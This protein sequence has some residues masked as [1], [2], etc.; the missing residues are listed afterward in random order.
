MGQAK[1]TVLGHVCTN[2]LVFPHP[3]TCKFAPRL[4]D[5]TPAAL[6]IEGHVQ[7]VSMVVDRE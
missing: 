7:A 2:L 4:L 6:G 3:K 1:E 5:C